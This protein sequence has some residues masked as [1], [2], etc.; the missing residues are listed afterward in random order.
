MKPKIN[1]QLKTSPL[2]VYVASIPEHGALDELFPR[3]R[4]AEVQACTNE[5]TKREKYFVW[6]L[7]KYAVQQTLGKDFDALSFQKN[8]NGKWTSEEFE[9]SLSH[10]DGAVCIALSK[11]PVG[12]DIQPIAL[13]KTE[14]VALKIFSEWEQAEYASLVNTE[15]KA[16]YFTRKW[17][18]RESIFKMLDLPSFFP[19]L[20]TLF[21]GKTVTKTVRISGKSYSL[22][23]A[24]E[25]LERLRLYENIDLCK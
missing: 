16:E 20:P 10:A 21:D 18:E 11:T 5:K 23:V 2:D 14:K 6:K 24:N 15:Q 22:S 8:K 25:S 7:L 4:N 9:F 19:A 1:E 12:V 17:T 13:P 3:E